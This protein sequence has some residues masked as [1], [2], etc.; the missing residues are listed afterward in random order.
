[1]ETKSNEATELRPE[2]AR[3][4]D[5]PFVHMNITE[6]I[7]NLKAEP[8]WQNSDRNA[9]TIY[10]TN[11]MRIVLVGLHQDAELK[12]HMAEGIISVQVLEGEMEFGTDN[13]SVVL[14][15]GQMLS[16]IHI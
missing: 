6:F 16:L 4:L 5:A 12:R 8:T 13:E 1:M 10:K 3:V 7:K 11:G 2:G 9:M 15:Q 14:S